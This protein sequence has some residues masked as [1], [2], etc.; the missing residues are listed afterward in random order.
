MVKKEDFGAKRFR[1]RKR[2]KPEYEQK[3]VDIARV[4]RVV[5]GGKRFSF[6]TVIVI[7]NKKGKVGV[8]VAK[9]PDMKASTE[10]SF[11]DAKKNLITI[12]F[13]GHTIPYPVFQKIGS[14]RVMLKPAVR[15]NGIV[16]GGAIRTVISL[17]GIS[18]I[19]GKM[20]GSKNRL[21]NARAA[22]EALKQFSVK[23]TREVV[24][25]EERAEKA[26]AVEK[27]KEEKVKKAEEKKK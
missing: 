9:G 18:D 2:E 26:K 17:A 23:K 4:T 15:G 22:I 20:L 3:V 11:A 21:N 7:G 24:L 16:A 1:G 27:K 12:N 8:G 10:K 14:A 6:R 25:E 19:S 5:K 13:K